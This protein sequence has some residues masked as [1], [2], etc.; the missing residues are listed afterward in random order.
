MLP[1]T[2]ELTPRQRGLGLKFGNTSALRRIL[3]LKLVIAS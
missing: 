1:G 3:M 2:M